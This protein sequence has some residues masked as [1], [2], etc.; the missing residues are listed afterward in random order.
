VGVSQKSLSYLLRKD[1]V[2]ELHA[3]R[4]EASRGNDRIWFYLHT[5]K[6]DQP[7]QHVKVVNTSYSFCNTVQE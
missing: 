7:P 2:Q 1:C 6:Q 4:G 5:L 3:C